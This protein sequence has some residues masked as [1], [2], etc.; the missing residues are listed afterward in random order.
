MVLLVGFSS[1]AYAAEQVVTPALTEVTLDPGGSFTV[2]V[3]YDTANPADD[4]LTGFGLRLHF[5]SSKLSF[6]GLTQAFQT[7]LLAADSSPSNDNGNFDS[8]GATD[9]FVNVAWEDLNGQW[10]GAGTTPVTLYQASFT[11]SGTGVGN[12]RFS[13]SGTA[14]GYTFAST[15]VVVTIQPADVDGDGVDNA[16]DNCPNDSN[17][18]Q[19][20][21]DGDDV[22]DVCDNDD[23]GDGIPDNVEGSGDPDNDGVGNSL[24][25]DSDG[26]GLEDIDEGANDPDNDGIPNYLDLDSDGDGIEDSVEGLTD[27]DGDGIADAF[28]NVDDPPG[29]PLIR[30]L[31]FI[32]TN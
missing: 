9:R 13:S 4:T 27:S 8:D 15:P 18:N 12:V 26:D 19:L 20:D 2:T 31:P 5:D 24:D 22:G 7:N 29:S 28:D 3:A 14:V 17:A 30:L 21:T 25:E 23:D 11:A 16:D 32:E 10:P 6:N 1:M